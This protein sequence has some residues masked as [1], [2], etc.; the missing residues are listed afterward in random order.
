M[1][2]FLTVMTFKLLPTVILLTQTE[3]WPLRVDIKDCLAV[4]SKFWIGGLRYLMWKK[5]VYVDNLCR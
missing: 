5:C 1:S 4:D 3:F 2:A